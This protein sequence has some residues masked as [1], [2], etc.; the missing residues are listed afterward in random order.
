MTITPK[1]PLHFVP[2]EYGLS[3]AHLKRIDSIAL[4]GIHQGAYPG[5]QV[6]V[7]KNGHIMFD[8]AFGTYTG[9]GSPPIGSITGTCKC[10]TIIPPNPAR[11]ASLKG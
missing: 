2:E 10:P 3:S 6:V 8:K 11:M 9:K 7:L 1:T 5:C 4:D